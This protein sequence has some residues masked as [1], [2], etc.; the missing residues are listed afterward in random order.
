MRLRVFLCA[1]ALHSRFLGELR[2]KNGF[3]M[4]ELSPYDPRAGFLDC[5]ENLAVLDERLRKIIQK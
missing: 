1:V 4:K 3:D 5:I 2:F